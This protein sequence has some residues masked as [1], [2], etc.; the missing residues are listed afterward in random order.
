MQRTHRDIWKDKHQRLL[1][2]CC[3]NTDSRTRTVD[4]LT[5]SKSLARDGIQLDSHLAEP[6]HISRKVYRIQ[7]TC[8][9]DHTGRSKTRKKQ[10]RL[11][12]TQQ[13]DNR[14]CNPILLP[15]IIMHTHPKEHKSCIACITPF[16][17]TRKLTSADHH[18]T[19]PTP[20]QLRKR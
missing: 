14:A 11:I 2:K 3:G 1:S 6:A 8:L 15:P 16:H 18:Q 19:F 12:S 4:L 10:D 20:H 7:L 5:L 9:V 13:K 17:A